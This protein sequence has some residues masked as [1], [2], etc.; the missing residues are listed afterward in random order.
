VPPQIL[1]PQRPLWQEDLWRPRCGTRCRPRGRHGQLD[2]SA[3]GVNSTGL[4]WLH[5]NRSFLGWPFHVFSATYVAA[6]AS[7]RVGPFWFGRHR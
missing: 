4:D 2:S 6:L 1:S 7:H 5:R 3:V